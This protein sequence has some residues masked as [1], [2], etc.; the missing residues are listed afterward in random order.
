M[1]VGC[2]FVVVDDV[3]DGAAISLTDSD[4]CKV[5]FCNFYLDTAS[6]G[7]IH[8]DADNLEVGWC[9]GVGNDDTS[10][11]A[12][13]FVLIN[14]ADATSELSVHDCNVTLFDGMITE[15]STAVAAHGLGT[16]DL[17]TA[18]TVDSMEVENQYQ[19]NCALGCNLFF[20]TQE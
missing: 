2:N 14:G 15:A 1:I 5:L 3:T 11:S 9:N 20:D 13:S 19:G 7:I 4:D 8:H 18:A 16:G 12:G 10:A 17:A 6:D